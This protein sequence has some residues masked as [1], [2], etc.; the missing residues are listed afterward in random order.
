MSLYIKNES[1]IDVKILWLILFLLK[2]GSKFLYLLLIYLE[3]KKVLNIVRLYLD[4]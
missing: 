4:V 3:G 1:V 2:E